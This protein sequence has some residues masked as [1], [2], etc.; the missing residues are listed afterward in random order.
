LFDK[1][2]EY[3]TQK[4][5]ISLMVEKIGQVLRNSNKKNQLFISDDSRVIN[6]SM[7]PFN[8]AFCKK[9]DIGQKR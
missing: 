5:E 4:I 2:K 1:K 3:F 6:L 8:L 7:K 9:D